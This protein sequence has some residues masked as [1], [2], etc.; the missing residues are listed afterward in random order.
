LTE[1][2]FG[3]VLEMSQHYEVIIEQTPHTNH[4]QTDAGRIRAVAGDIIISA[5]MKSLTN[6][7]SE[8]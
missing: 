2:E 4:F 5:V 7:P 1:I 6:Y 3:I 8:F